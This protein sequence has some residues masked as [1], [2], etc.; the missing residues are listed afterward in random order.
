MWRE[1]S[2]TEDPKKYVKERSGN[3][4]LSPLGYHLGDAALHGT[5]ERNVRFYCLLGNPICKTR[6]WKWAAVSIEASLGY[7]DGGS[8]T[9]DFERQ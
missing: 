7:A 2:F 8:C 4:H 6:P 9:V 1:G 5:W 3:R